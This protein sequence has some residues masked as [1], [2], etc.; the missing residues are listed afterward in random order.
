MI[1]ASARSV[2]AC[3]VQ[4]RGL[5]SGHRRRRPWC[6]DRRAD[7]WRI[8]RR[9]GAATTPGYYGYGYDGSG[10]NRY[11]SNA[12]SYYGP[13]YGSGS[14]SGYNGSGYNGAGYYGYGN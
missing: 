8:G 1:R 12:P 13:G 5:P 11:G 2:A 3:S 6:G 9:R 14:G 4:P 10:Y 7:R